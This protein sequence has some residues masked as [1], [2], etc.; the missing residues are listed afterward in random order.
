MPY[1]IP[2]EPNE[3][4]QPSNK[5]IKNIDKKFRPK[6]RRKSAWSGSLYDLDRLDKIIRIADAF[7]YYISLRDINKI[8]EYYS[9]LH[10][11][12]LNLR[13]FL[14]D[15]ERDGWDKNVEI[16]KKM[17]YADPNKI[18]IKIFDILM[19]FHK[20]LLLIRQEV[21]LGMGTKRRVPKD[22]KERQAFGVYE[23][24]DYEDDDD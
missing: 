2:N 9:I 10:T 8:Q 19:G 23:G 18:N 20:D 24:D 5:E 12:Y 6:N 13:P 11:F 16:I 15:I 3:P 1:N 22:V 21:G 4:A 7:S 14:N 17:V